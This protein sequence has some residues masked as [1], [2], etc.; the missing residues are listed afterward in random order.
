[1]KTII[2]A[3]DFSAAAENAA[4]YAAQMA[5]ILDAKL[6]LLH[7]YQIPAAY[8]E[9]PVLISED[10]MGRTAQNNLDSLKQDLAATTGFKLD[11]ETQLSMGVFFLELK[12]LCEEADPYVVVMGSQGTTSA[13]RLF[14]GSHT[15]NAMK[16][17]NW[18]LITVPPSV[19]FDA[20]KKIGFACDFEK[21]MDSTPVD[22]IKTL[23][24]DF[25]AELHV[26]NTGKQKVFNPNIVFESG[27]LQEMLAGLKPSY[28]FTTNPDTDEGIMDFAERNHLDLLIVLPKRHGLVERLVH[29]S[30]T[31]ELVLHSHVPVMAL[32]Q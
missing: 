25:N 21:V 9:V 8:M 30:H 10:E 27:L 32:H 14:F 31:K 2:V 16:Q 13:E 19:K 28:H 6:I 4:R 24:N 12:T 17:L 29:K 15:V 7:V 1:M 11:I 18:P 23:V 26:L 5:L 20:I 22:E 3:T